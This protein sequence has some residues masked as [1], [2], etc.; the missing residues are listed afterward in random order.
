MF[1]TND[2]TDA[3]DTG[4]PPATPAAEWVLPKP[5]EWANP[6]DPATWPPRDPW[7][8]PFPPNAG[9]GA[10]GAAQLL[11]EVLLHIP[12]EASQFAP[13][14]DDVLAFRAELVRDIAA[15]PNA[16]VTMGNEMP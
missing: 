7:P 1:D 8:Y 12:P 10:D 4:E 5:G 2:T 13:M 9:L 3:T 15:H 16:I 6:L 11:K 14:S